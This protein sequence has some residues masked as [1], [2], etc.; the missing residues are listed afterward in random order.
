MLWLRQPL[1]SSMTRM[2][3]GVWGC[4]VRLFAD[5]WARCNGRVDVPHRPQPKSVAVFSLVWFGPKC[6]GRQDV[7]DGQH[8]GQKRTGL[9]RVHGII[10]AGAWLGCASVSSSGLTQTEAVDMKVWVINLWRAEEEKVESWALQEYE[11][12]SARIR[13]LREDV[14]SEN[15]T[16][17]TL[18]AALEAKKVRGVPS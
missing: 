8:G 17:E 9:T 4:V 13:K 10:V 6:S 2:I 3:S 16:L 1:S 15:N 18:T 7:L 14:G 5:P 11:E 12:R